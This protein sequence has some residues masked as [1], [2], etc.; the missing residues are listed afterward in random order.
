[1]IPKLLDDI[2]MGLEADESVIKTENLNFNN[3]CNKE[4]M[5]LKFMKSTLI[6]LL[7]KGWSKGSKMLLQ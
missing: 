2:N 5:Q 1:M 6:Y 3:C 7:K 4:N